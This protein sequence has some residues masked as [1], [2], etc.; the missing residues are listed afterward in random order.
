MTKEEKKKLADKKYRDANKDKAKAWREANKETVKVKAKQYREANK[1]KLSEL[2][3]A[4][5]SKNKVTIDKQNKLYRDTNKDNYKAWVDANKDKINK[6][7]LEYYHKNKEHLSN[8]RKENYIKNKEMLNKKARERTAIK[9]NNNPL[10]KLTLYSR[11][12][13]RKALVRNGYTKKTKTYNILGC[14]FDEF[15]QYLESKFEPW[16]N[17]DNYGNPKD[18]VLEPNKTWDIDH[19]IPLNSGLNEDD[20]I[21]LNHYT[22]LQPLCSYTNRFIKRGYF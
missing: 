3:K 16:M 19:I 10:F 12:L 14:S 1:S 11:N 8:K 4:Y 2:G 22:N 21:R 20:V 15:K 9:L 7:K 18:G 17:W 5:K 13:I 6:R